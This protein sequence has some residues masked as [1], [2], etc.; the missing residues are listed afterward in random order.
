MNSK[1]Q[2][3]LIVFMILALF[4]AACDAIN[5]Q[6]TSEAEPTD[7]PVVITDTEIV[8]EGRIVPRETVQLSFF[9]NGQVEEIYV[10]EDD[11][12]EA[13]QVVALLGER[14]QLEANIANAEA[15]LLAANQAL[16]QLYEDTE[17][18]ITPTQLEIT[19]ANREV[20]DAQYTLDNF[21]VPQNLL[22]YSTMEAIDVT[23]AALD[24]AR[25]AFEP[26][27]YLSSSN[28]TRKD[29][30]DEL[31]E[32]QSDL[33]SSLRRLEYETALDQA[34]TKLDEALAAVVQMARGAGTAAGQVTAVAMN[35]A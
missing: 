33:D 9:T 8:S 23:R 11:L 4:A 13:G 27:K 1:I 25:A 19:L 16:D 31:E 3:I 26:Y 24:E 12:V 15:E 10:E 21:T 2:K 29:L 18:L 35:A 5:P 22:K 6:A 28:E 32:A 20:R 7:I 30:R 14:E 34:I 17:D